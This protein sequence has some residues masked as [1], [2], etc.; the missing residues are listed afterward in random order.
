[1]HQLVLFQ[2]AINTE[3]R[4]TCPSGIVAVYMEPD[5]W[6]QVVSLVQSVLEHPAAERAEFLK[7]ASAGDESLAREVQLLL[8]A[9]QKPGSFLET[10]A[11]D[12]PAGGLASQ[13]A[14]SAEAP[15]PLIGRTMLHYRVVERIGGGG[16]GVVY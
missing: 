2:H 14:Q 16:M 12:K 10:S 11:M 3:Q 1:M 6:R 5:R 9:Q 15:D 4:L 8:D 7:Q 13:I